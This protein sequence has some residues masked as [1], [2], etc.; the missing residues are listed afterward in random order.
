[1]R[2]VYDKVPGLS[3]EKSLPMILNKSTDTYNA[4][5]AEYKQSIHLY[6]KYYGLPGIAFS[7]L[8]LSIFGLDSIAVGFIKSKGV[9]ETIIGLVSVLCAVTGIIGTMVFQVISNHMSLNKIM[10]IGYLSDLI[11]LSLCLII[12]FTPFHR[13]GIMLFNYDLS[14]VLFLAGITLSRTGLWITD[15]ANNQLIQTT[16][17]NPALVGGMQN[18][19]N[20][21]AELTKFIITAT[22]SNLSQFYILVFVSFCSIAMATII[23]ITLT[24]HKHYNSS[25]QIGDEIQYEPLCKVNM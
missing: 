8:Y 11:P 13:L 19:L 12:V 17:P 9:S 16:T 25:N 5:V 4:D 24:I 20:T 18:S 2:I 14:I 23:S 21:A 22:L 10:T 15:L 7:L 3:R 1:M 6:L